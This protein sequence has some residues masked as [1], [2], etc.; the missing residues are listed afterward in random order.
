MKNVK[1][2]EELDIWIESRKLSKDI[3]RVFKTPK[4]FSDRPLSLQI[5]RSS[6]SIVDNIAEGFER[7]GNKEFLQYLWISKASAGECRSQLYR[8]LD[9]D[10]ISEDNFQ[11]LKSRVELISVKIYKFIKHLKESDFKG[12][13][14]S[15]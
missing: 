7:G 12:I 10:V 5:I 13:K 2:F 8:A 4:Y 3:Y 11:D 6:G 1:R 14:Y 9:H 15:N